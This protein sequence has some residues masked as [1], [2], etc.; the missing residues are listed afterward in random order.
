MKDTIYREDAIGA[1]AY[2][3]IECYE[4]RK[5]I[6]ALPSADRPQEWIPCSERL[7]SEFSDEERVLAT[8]EVDGLGVILMPAYD[9][10][11]WY[12]KGYI[13]AWMPLPKPWKGADDE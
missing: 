13:T 12:L 6:R 8:T 3:T 9:V 7:P 1:C 4:A 2:E 10:K 11:S 5:A